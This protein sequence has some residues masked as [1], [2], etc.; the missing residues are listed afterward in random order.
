MEVLKQQH[1]SSKVTERKHLLT[2]RVFNRN[3]HMISQLP[4]SNCYIPSTTP[5]YSFFLFVLQ[6][7]AL[8]WTPDGSASEN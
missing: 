3:A 4:C 7:P 5:S 8:R 1:S 6:S 2:F